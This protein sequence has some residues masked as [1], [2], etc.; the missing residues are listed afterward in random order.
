MD[1]FSLLPFGK[2]GEADKFFL[3]LDVQRIV[4]ECEEASGDFSPMM[5]FLESNVMPLEG[6]G[7]CCGGSV[8]VDLGTN[9]LSFSG[10]NLFVSA[11]FWSFLIRDNIDEIGGSV[12]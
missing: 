11:S 10:W 3:S 7:N 8:T 6:L 4:S 2:T 12:G 1:V 5:Q 9:I